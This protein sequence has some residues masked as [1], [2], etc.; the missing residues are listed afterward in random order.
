MEFHEARDEAAGFALGLGGEEGGESGEE[1]RTGL[2]HGVWSE[3]DVRG[4]DFEGFAEGV[5]C[6]VEE[7]EEV[8]D[9]SEDF[10]GGGGGLDQGGGP[11][12]EG[13]F[14]EVG[15]AFGGWVHGALN[16]GED[17]VLEARG[18]IVHGL[19]QGH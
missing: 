3:V 19:D 8:V 4:G 9:E 15:A 17:Y 6:G 7:G 11:E 18:L 16:E 2:Q 5:G 12:V 1:A 14:E 10:G 13:V